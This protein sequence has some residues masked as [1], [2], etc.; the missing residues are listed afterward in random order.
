MGNDNAYSGRGCENGRENEKA[1]S[2]KFY[3]RSG[4]GN[5][6]YIENYPLLRKGRS[7]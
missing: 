6:G 7:S 3:E 1:T 5:I 4:V 2:V